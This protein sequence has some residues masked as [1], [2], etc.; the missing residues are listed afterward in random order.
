MPKFSDHIDFIIKQCFK[1]SLDNGLQFVTPEVFL[2]CLLNYD[3]DF[4]NFVQDDLGLSAQEMFEELAAKTD[5]IVPVFVNETKPAVESFMFKKMKAQAIEMALGADVKEIDVPHFIFSIIELKE[6]WAKK[7]LLQNVDMRLADFKYLLV[8]AY[9]KYN[10]H[11]EAET[12]GKNLIDDFELGG[13]SFQ[14]NADNS[15][16]D[17]LQNVKFD[18]IDGE[19][20]GNNSADNDSNK[21][22]DNNN[23]DEN[24]DYLDLDKFG[25]PEWLKGAFKNATIIEGPMTSKKGHSSS[26]KDEW[27]KNVVCIN[28]VVDQHNPLVG[29]KYELDRTIQIL[30]RCDKNNPL[31]IGEPGVGKTALVYGLAQRIKDGDVPDKLKNSRI[32]S[33]DMASLLAGSQFRG[34]FEKKIKT[35]MDGASNEEGA[36]VYIDEIHTIVGAGQTSDSTLDAANMLKPYLESGKIRFIGSTTYK[37]YN[38]HFGK[39]AG[40]TRRFQNVDILEP[41]KDEAVQILNGL[42]NRYESFH[43]VTFSEGV[44][45]YAVQMSAKYINDRFLPDKAID[46]IDEAGAYRQMHK[47]D[48]EVQTVDKELIAQVVS[49]IC[50]VDLTAVSDDDSAALLDLDKRMGEQIFGQPEAI[51]QVVEAVQMGKAGL[52]DD[53][54][55]VASFLFVGPT[56]VGKTEVTKVLA[57]Q[58]GLELVRFD[59][60]EYVEKH[61][62]AKLIGAPAGYVGYEEGGLLTDAIRKT[63]NCVL[64]LD[65][66]EKAHQDIYNV[67]LQVMD[68]AKLTD[69]KGQKADFRHVILIMTSNAGAQYAA[70]SSVGFA[71]TSTA[72][73][74]MMDQVRRTFKPEFINRLSATVVFN[75]MNI[76]MAERILNKKLDILQQRLSA[77]NVTMVLDDDA[78]K[79]LLDLGYSKKYG[80]R[81]MDRAIQHNL[82]PLLMKQILFGELKNGGTANV[83]VNE[84]SLVVNP[85]N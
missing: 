33:V 72:G 16:D 43:N 23:S 42:K 29:R 3:E 67:L 7:L 11:H 80:A 32:Y 22:S 20:S 12:I 15:Y 6:S 50:K 10:G 60:S 28:D 31:H 34:D 46:L 18:D 13:R 62:V 70:Q 37:E 61:T 1:Y 69:N 41:S 45:E 51:K 52:L 47:L 83:S 68:Y 14:V 2:C 65:E 82:T 84:D 73:S 38:K 27:K 78:R 63:P 56:G 74:A 30:C 81:E 26:R 21:D 4:Y 54:K 44:L 71:S 35:I 24:D 53:D 77:K 8:E 59:M 5:E 40:L 79:K 76:E 49:K 57:K 9:S 66:I 25:I 17:D 64:L 19:N 36:I 58:L 75:D 39:T 48:G 85:S 55:P